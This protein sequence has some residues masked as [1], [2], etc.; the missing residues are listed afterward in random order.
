[1][2]ELQTIKATVILIF[3]WKFN[4][5]VFIKQFK[6]WFYLSVFEQKQD[7]YSKNFISKT[8]SCEKYL[9]WVRESHTQDCH[10]SIKFQIYQQV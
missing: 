9:Y 10:T 6:I 1:M 8:A 2:A 7:I 5:F 4:M 3:D